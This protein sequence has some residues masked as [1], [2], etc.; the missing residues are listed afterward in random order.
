MEGKYNYYPKRPDIG[1]HDHIEFL[2][3]D[4]SSLVYA[5]VRKFGTMCLVKKG[6]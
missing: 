1:K 4:G 2:M 5:D 3:S 6:H